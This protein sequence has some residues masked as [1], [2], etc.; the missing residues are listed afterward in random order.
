MASFR[1]QLTQPWRK[2]SLKTMQSLHLLHVT[3]FGLSLQ[4]CIHQY[5][6]FMISLQEQKSY[7]R[8]G[9]YFNYFDTCS[10]CELLMNEWLVTSFQWR[11]PVFSLF[12]SLWASSPREKSAGCQGSQSWLE[13]G[14]VTCLPAFVFL[15]KDHSL[16]S[17][18]DSDLAPFEATPS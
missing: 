17:L 18:L 16:S 4:A 2:H 8:P 11:I 1:S 13:K 15:R 10:S 14:S 12:Q 7:R 9:L 6:V 5:T 3:S